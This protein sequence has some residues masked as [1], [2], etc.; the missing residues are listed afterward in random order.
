VETTNLPRPDKNGATGL[1]D[2]VARDGG[3]QT[4]GGRGM[5]FEWRGDSS[6]GGSW[7]AMVTR[8]LR[9]MPV[10]WSKVPCDLTWRSFC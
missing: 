5:R 3:N 4:Q 7:R 10:P 2:P 8:G 1:D 6:T 9:T